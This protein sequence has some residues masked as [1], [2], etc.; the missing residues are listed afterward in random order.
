M[1][2]QRIG[3]E[4]NNRARGYIASGEFNGNRM[5]QH[6]Q[7]Q[8]VKSYCD[9]NDL[10]FVL[11]RAEYW[12]DGSTQCQLWAA[13]KE[14]F[15][16]IVFFSLW[17]LP[18]NKKEREKVYE[19]CKLNHII[20]HFATERMH[21]NS[22]ESPFA[23]IEILIQSNLVMSRSPQSHDY[24][25]TLKDLIKIERHSGANCCDHSYA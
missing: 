5:P 12:I 21:A 10:E 18:T 2:I 19:Y 24:L 7:N 15:K 4:M 6:L 25:D 20:L 1:N 22:D 8:I 11:S 13:L 16:N 17:Q 23:D 14:G 3:F 9:A